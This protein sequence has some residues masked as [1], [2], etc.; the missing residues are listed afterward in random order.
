MNTTIYFL[1]SKKKK[2]KKKKGTEQ[3]K[4]GN[5]LDESLCVLCKANDIFVNWPQL[6]FPP[7]P[8]FLPN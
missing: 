3:K 5:V 2:K 8:S 1:N 4:R 7:P 6:D